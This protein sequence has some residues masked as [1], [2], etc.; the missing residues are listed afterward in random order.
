MNKFDRL[1][2]KEL[3]IANGKKKVSFRCFFWALPLV[4]IWRAKEKFTDLYD[5]V[6]LGVGEK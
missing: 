3:Y 6:F 2:E 5:A 1:V 4:L